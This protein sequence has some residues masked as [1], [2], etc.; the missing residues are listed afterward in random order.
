MMRLATKRSRQR[1]ISKIPTKRPSSL[2]TPKLEDTTLPIALYFKNLPSGYRLSPEDR[3][4]LIRFVQEMMEE[5]LDR[6][7]QLVEVNYPGV[8]RHDKDDD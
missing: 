1:P 6:R 4:S 8:L 3:A 2:P 7:L 5:D